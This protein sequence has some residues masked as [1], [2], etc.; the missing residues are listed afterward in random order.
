M[1]AFD[2]DKTHDRMAIID[3]LI[4]IIPLQSPKTSSNWE[5]VSALC[6]RTVYSCL[7][8]SNSAFHVVLVCNERP[9]GLSEHER[10]SV[11]TVDYPVPAP[12]TKARMQDKF[13][14]LNMGMYHMRSHAPCYFMPVDADDCVHRGLAS[15]IAQDTQAHG[16]FMDQGYLHDEGSRVLYLQRRDFI[17]RCGTSYIVRCTPEEI[18]NH[19]DADPDQYFLTANGHSVI[20]E[21]CAQKG[22]PLRRLNIPGTVY[23]GATGEND[24]K[25]ALKKWRSRRIFLS[26][27]LNTRWL[28]P[29][30]RRQYG[31]Y[32]LSACSRHQSQMKEKNTTTDVT[33]PAEGECTK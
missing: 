25:F 16:W 5:R 17:L 8:Q 28:S 27:L 21:A 2:R 30:K 26:K 1:V 18:P 10:L 11:V 6:L 29:Y 12:N 13:R 4:F 9:L 14:K 33:D 20:R 24:S 15:V 23:V 22:C 7:G 31:L 3:M 19:P 32:P